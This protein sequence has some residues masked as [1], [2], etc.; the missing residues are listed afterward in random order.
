MCGS[1]TLSWASTNFFIGSVSLF[2]NDIRRVSN[3][4]NIMSH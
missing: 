2:V 3:E 4:N 1:S